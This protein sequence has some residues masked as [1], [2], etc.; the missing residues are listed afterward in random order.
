MV[1]C[2]RPFWCMCLL[3]YYRKCYCLLHCLTH[4]YVSYVEQCEVWSGNC[5]II[6]IEILNERGQHKKIDSRMWATTKTTTA[7]STMHTH[8][9]M[10]TLESWRKTIF[11]QFFL[12]SFISFFLESIKRFIKLVNLHTHIDCQR[13]C[14]AYFVSEWICVRISW[15][16][17]FSPSANTRYIHRSVCMWCF[18]VRCVS[19]CK[20]GAFKCHIDR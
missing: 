18:L 16:F 5:E 19:P 15:W 14:I 6:L 13:I 10:H 4:K 3:H 11:L 9:V 8:T 2:C 1:R 7:E 17:L 12:L 20:S